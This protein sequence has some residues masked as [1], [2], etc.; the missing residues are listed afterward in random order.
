MR[1]TPLLLLLLAALSAGCL[2]GDEP[3]PSGDQQAEADAQPLPPLPENFTATEQV[4]GGVDVYNFL[5]GT[6]A[7]GGAPC[8]MSVS[9]C[10]RY[11]VTLERS[12]TIAVALDWGVPGH[13]FDVYLMEDGTDLSEAMGAQGATSLTVDPHEEFVVSGVPP[14]DYEIV[15]SHWL[16]SADTFTLAVT[17][18]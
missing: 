15:V 4:V 6:P 11:P 1:A 9:S 17:F 5:P 14:G 3:T 18:E 16:V 2:G 7:G 12:A 13:D 10:T 8:S